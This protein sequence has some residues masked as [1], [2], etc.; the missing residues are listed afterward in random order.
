M[1]ITRM[2]YGPG[3]DLPVKASEA[4]TAGRLV[5]VAAGLSGRNPVVKQAGAGAAPLGVAAHDCPADAYVTVYRQGVY[6]LVASGAV[7][8]GDL[9]AVAADGGVAVAG[10]GE[11]HVGLALS[12]AAAGFVTVALN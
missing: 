12:N 1:A 3:A 5:E 11:N 6:D 2:H 7:A 10:E 8:A 9:V 4:L